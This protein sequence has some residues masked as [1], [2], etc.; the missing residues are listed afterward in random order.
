MI[1]ILHNRRLD[2][3]NDQELVALLDRGGLTGEKRPCITIFKL[4]EFQFRIETNGFVLSASIC[5]CGQAP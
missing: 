4:C 5:Y 2:D 3:I 1:V